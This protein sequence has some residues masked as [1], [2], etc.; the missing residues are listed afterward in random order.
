MFKIYNVIMLVLTMLVII[1]FFMP[2]VSVKSEQVGMF[3]KILTGKNQDVV[4]NIS[5][6]Q[7]P[8]MV[9]SPDA[10]LMI[11]VIKIFNPGVK[12]VD[13]KSFLI[14]VVPFL[15][16]IIFIISCFFG[17]NKW[18]NLIISIIG[19][20]IFIVTVYKIN[21]TDLNKL[22]L[23]VEIGPGLWLTLW[24]YLFMGVIGFLRFLKLS[25]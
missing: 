4:D 14:W 16:V 3:T 21:T 17:K 23:K 12:D 20:A 15:A 24:L 7:V 2:W 5:A 22:V 6:F 10:R 18:V 19:A 1:A 9:N 11:S 13:K 8:I 25:K